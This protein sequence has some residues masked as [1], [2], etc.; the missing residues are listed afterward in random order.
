MIIPL[1]AGAIMM[2]YAVAGLFFF[3]FW[4]QTRD[5][6]FAMFAIA[7]WILS[8]NYLILT[9]PGPTDEFLPLH[10]TIRALAFLLILMGII[11]KNRARKAKRG[12]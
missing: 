3:K 8:L 11:D 2:C 4:R 9:P 7:F 6:L 5:R 12:Q 10:Y 1:L